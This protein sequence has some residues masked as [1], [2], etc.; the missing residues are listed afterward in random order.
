MPIAP[1]QA[2]RIVADFYDIEQLQVAALDE[3]DGPFVTLTIRAGAVPAEHFVRI[4]PDVA[5]GPVDLHDACS[6]WRTQLEW[7][8]RAAQRLSPSHSGATGLV[9]SRT[10]TVA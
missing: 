6:T 2:Q 8:V 5:V 1:D 4:D 9:R 7:F 3:L 10:E